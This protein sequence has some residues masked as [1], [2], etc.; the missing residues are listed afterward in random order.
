MFSD[1]AVLDNQTRFSA[2]LDELDRIDWEALQRCDYTLDRNNPGKTR[3]YLAEALI[4]GM[5]P[6]SSLLTLAC[7]DAEQKAWVE[8]LAR[9]ESISCPVLEKR[10]WYF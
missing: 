6:A 2:N 10:D 4:H 5:M 7:Y 1:A 9:S 3:R 8:A